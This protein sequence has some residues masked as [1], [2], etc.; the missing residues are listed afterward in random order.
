VESNWR[1]NVWRFGLTQ[2]GLRL[3]ARLVGFPLVA[4]TDLPHP[5]FGHQA[6]FRNPNDIGD[7]TNVSLLPNHPGFTRFPY[8]WDVEPD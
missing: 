4:L 6:F 3:A 2:P 8:G 7:W 5:S 1:L